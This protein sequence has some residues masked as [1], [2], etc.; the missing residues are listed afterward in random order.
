MNDLLTDY[1]IVIT[2]ELIWADMDAYQHINNAVYFTYFEIARMAYFEKIG[3]SQ[4]KE[5]HNIGPILASTKADFKAPLKYPD[6]I[7]IA[8]KITNLASKKLS[9]QYSIH[10]QTLNNIVA[11]GEALIVYFDYTNGK[12]CEIPEKIV[13]QI[14]Q[15]ENNVIQ[16]S[17]DAN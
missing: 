13:N 7:N 2:Q 12:S 11:Q 5:Q 9:M 17:P 15:I 10:S 1:L 3:V 8:A 14:R 4:Y 6:T 16:E